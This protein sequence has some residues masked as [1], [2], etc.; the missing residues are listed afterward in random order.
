MKKKASPPTPA[1]DG[2]VYR[3][4]KTSKLMSGI[5][6]RNSLLPLLAGLALLFN[7]GCLRDQCEATRTYRLWKPRYVLAEEFRKPI[8]ATAARQ[9]CEPGQLYYYNDYLLIAEKGEGVHIID[10]REPANPVFVAFLPIAGAEDMAVY[11]GFLYVN[12]YFDLVVFNLSNPSSPQYV[13][14]LEEAF[15]LM[16]AY[17]QGIGYLVGYDETNETVEV[18]CSDPRINNN[19][20]W[21]ENMTGIFVDVAF[22]ISN[23]AQSNTNSGTPVTGI[24]GSLA[25]FTVAS[26]HLYVIDEWSM[27]LFSLAQP[28]SPQRGSTIFIGWGIET[29]FPYNNNLFIGSQTGMYIYDNSNPQAPVQLG[30]F[31]HAR[32]CDPVFASGNRAYV[33]LRDGTTCDNFINQLDVVDISDLRNPRLVRTHPMHHPIGLSLAGD[34]LFICEDEQGVKV[35]DASDDHLIGQ[36]LLARAEGFTAR[37]VI[38]LPAQKV[39]IVIGPDGLRQ[40]DFSNRSELKLLSTLEICR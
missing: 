22:D 2:R 21:R 40:F 37:D 25:R 20:F 32:A 14:R 12:N 16:G 27:R 30:V 29:I 18:D 31:Q 35:F 7:S 36:R 11:N 24:G 9:L 15:P 28:A 38:T 6:F 33:T 23:V 34:Q 10:N 8:E 39:A 19:F 26:G 17:N 1:A 5:T 13:N 4:N 3:G